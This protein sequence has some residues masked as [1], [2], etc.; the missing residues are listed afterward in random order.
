MCSYA[1]ARPPTPL[2][3]HRG[4]IIVADGDGGVAQ[5]RAARIL[6][7]AREASDGRE[8]GREPRVDGGTR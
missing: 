3:L 8:R 1:T 2:Q 7:Q 5:G 6:G 4:D